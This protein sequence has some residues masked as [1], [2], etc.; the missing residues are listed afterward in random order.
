MIL[1][2]Q[3]RSVIGVEQKLASLGVALLRV[4]V[5][6]DDDV[7][8]FKPF[9][10]TWTPFPATASVTGC[11]SA[12]VP[13]AVDILLALDNEDDAFKRDRLDEIGKLVGDLADAPDRP[14]VLSV[15]VLSALAEV[16]GVEAA[17]LE[18]EGAP[19]VAIVV[20]GDDLEWPSIFAGSDEPFTL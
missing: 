2:G 13:H 14:D 1:A 10:V 11:G 20:A 19:F 18:E 12:F 9:G 4:V 6:N 8:A 15:R 5:G 7:G 16:F 3:N 17:D